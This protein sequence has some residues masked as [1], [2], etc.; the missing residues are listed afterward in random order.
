MS[1]MPGIIKFQSFKF[2]SYSDKSLGSD[3][4][5]FTVA[6][7]GRAEISERV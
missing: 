2:Q 6:P 4:K 3:V 5:N 1:R 7:I